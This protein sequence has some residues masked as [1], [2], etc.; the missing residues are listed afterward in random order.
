MEKTQRDVQSE[1]TR[2]KI[3][4]AAM[5]LFVRK[6]FSATSI[7]DLAAAVDMTKGALYHHF[8]NKD[9]LFF[10]VVEQIR[11]TWAEVVGRQVLQETDAL[12]KLEVLIDSHARLIPE[13]DSF[14][15]VLNGLM[16]E[17]DGVNREF[18]AL[19]QEVYT[20][21]VDL[22]EKI[23]RQGQGT[24]QVRSDLDP[25]LTA[26]SIVGVL[27]GTGCGY[28]MFTRLGAPYAELMAASRRMI[29]AG[30]RT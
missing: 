22:I 12:R 19:L 30:V 25:R 5:R 10:A 1:M 7:A 8:A 21:L 4:R 18:L 16:A 29:L 24:G 28:A 13:N 9:A 6:G 26:F 15:L 17:M 27:R 11:R 14:C 20:D 2:E 23:V 3:V